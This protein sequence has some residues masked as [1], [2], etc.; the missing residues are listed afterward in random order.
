[1][2]RKLV[3]AAA[4]SGTMAL[5][6]IGVASASSPSTSTSAP[7]SSSSSSG[8]GSTPA[9]R[10]IDCSKAM[11]RI[12]KINAREAKGTAWVSKAQTREA[13]ATKANHTAVAKRIGRRITRVQKLQT[14]G[15]KVEARI[16]AKCGSGTSSTSGTGST[17]ATS[18]S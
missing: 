17:S 2:L 11:A 13:A 9:H 3:A 16:S 7:S 6:G 4:L 10:T 12:P 8:T 14:F 15:H 18:V 5:G 1:M